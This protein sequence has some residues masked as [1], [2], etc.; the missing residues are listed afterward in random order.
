MISTHETTP[1]EKSRR[2]LESLKKTVAET[3]E[4]KRKLGQYAVIW[5]GKKPVQS[6]PDAPV[7][8]D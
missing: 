4:I 2:I 6:G 8:K 1:S 7:S 5:D 3:L